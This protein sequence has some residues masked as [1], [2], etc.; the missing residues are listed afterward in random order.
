MKLLFMDEKGPQNSFK[1]S[2]PFD[3]YNKIAHANDK[4]GSYVANVIEIDQKDYVLI[5]KEY[6]KT[7]SEYLLTRGQLKE[8]LEKKDKELKGQNLLKKNFDF[9]IASMRTEEI[10]FY[11][12]LFEILIEYNVDNLLFL[13]NKV[14]IIT[15]SRLINF[16]Y[17]LDENIG[18]PAFFI[19]YVITKYLEIEASETVVKSFLDKSVPT[20]RLLELIR[21]DMKRII[22]ENL[23]N[24]RMQTQIISYKQFLKALEIVLDSDVELLEP[25]LAMEFDWEKVK[26]NFDLW[27]T[28]R[29]FYGTEDDRKLFLDEGIPKDT[30]KDLKINSIQE[31]CDSKDFIG[32]Q[33]TDM[34]VALIGKLV[35]KL[36]YI[37]KYDFKRPDKVVLLPSNYFDITKEQFDLIKKIYLY[38]IDRKGQY[39]Y[40]NDSYFDSSILL[41]SYLEYIAN[42][43]SFDLYNKNKIDYHV[44]EHFKLFKD[45]SDEKFFNTCK[46]EKIIKKDYGSTRKA[47]EEKVYRPL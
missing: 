27:M 19:K 31:N 14:S 28:E 9:G 13:I 22:S 17:Y 29:D 34:I 5:E 8:S 2:Y 1:I 11:T 6:K 30:F 40:I 21:D 25:D 15:S 46:N 10:K 39:H 12:K 26:W 33:I 3:R 43:N 7:V 38:I 16:I 18:Y 45:I 4:M 37:T 20:H 23:T 35:S 47:I 36:N 24:K 44:S 32:L 42:F 41:Q